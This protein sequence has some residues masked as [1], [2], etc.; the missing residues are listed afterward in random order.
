MTVTDPSTLC[1]SAP[2][3]TGTSGFDGLLLGA[4]CFYDTVDGQLKVDLGTGVSLDEC[5]NN[6]STV[7]QA[8]SCL[9]SLPFLYDPYMKITCAKSSLVRDRF[10]SLQGASIVLPDVFRS[11]GVVPSPT[12]SGSTPQTTSEGGLHWPFHVGSQLFSSDSNYEDRVVAKHA[13]SDVHLNMEPNV[14]LRVLYQTS[15][16]FGGLS[17]TDEEQLSLGL[18]LSSLH[19]DNLP[20]ADLTPFTPKLFKDYP[21]GD[22]FSDYGSYK[23]TLATYPAGALTFN[24]STVVGR[25]QRYYGVRESIADVGYYFGPKSQDEEQGFTVSMYAR[26]TAE[27]DGFCSCWPMPLKH[28]L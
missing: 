20:L 26:L 18:N 21:I 6:P 25:A 4:T 22:V 11:G 8:G 15:A 16:S 23:S 24:D 7:L 1:T 17:P 28:R 5:L 2:Y 3:A 13:A 12:D 19:L 9:P 27:S 10:F 14:N